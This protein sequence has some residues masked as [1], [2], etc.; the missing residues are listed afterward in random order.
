[1]L[2]CWAGLM[3]RQDRVDLL[4]EAIRVFIH[5]RGR[6]DTRFVLLGEGECLAELRERVS[7]LDLD[8]WVG[9]PGFLCEAD[10]FTYY[11][12]ADVGLDASLQVEVSPVKVVEYMA[13]GMPVVAFDLP[14]TTPLLTGAGV[15][16]PP[17]D[18]VGL[19]DAL[20][21][22][23]DDP[24]RARSLGERGAARVAEE[25]GWEHQARTYVTAIERIARRPV[26][27]GG[28]RAPR[29]GS[30]ALRSAR[31]RPVA[32]HPPHARPGTE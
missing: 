7:D 27:V 23:L 25:L 4:L 10:L 19:A 11:A 3:G 6:R 20:G 13:F 14:E 8:A 2:C 30:G 18:V 26:A 9:F 12:T 16:V 21:A 28:T 31:D 1:H 5:V 15:V 17:G 24:Q 22:L 32:T 29:S